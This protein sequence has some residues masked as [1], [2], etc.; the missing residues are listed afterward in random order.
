MISNFKLLSAYISDL[1]TGEVSD[2]T[3]E[4]LKALI[5]ESGDP[6]DPVIVSNN[7]II[8]INSQYRNGD[9]D[10]NT[11]INSI[12]Y[13]FNR[14][15]LQYYNILVEQQPLRIIMENALDPSGS[16]NDKFDRIYD[17]IVACDQDSIIRT[18]FLYNRLTEIITSG[19]DSE[20]LNT[21]RSINSVL[22]D[23]DIT[24]Y[25]ESSIDM[26]RIISRI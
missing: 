1:H 22:A 14:I 18:C 13:E 26:I 3:R 16:F 2:L 12:E 5:I 8:A 9:I 7:I 20:G 10:I 23:I 15:G 6:Y 25:I 4:Q 24:D 19:V 21:I 11:A 17:K